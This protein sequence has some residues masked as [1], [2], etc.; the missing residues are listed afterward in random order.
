M[1]D[2]DGVYNVQ[3]DRVWTVVKL[4]RKAGETKMF[5]KTYGM[6]RCLFKRSYTI[7]YSRQRYDRYIKEVLPVVIKHGNNDDW[8]C[9][10]DNATPD[11]H[12]LTQEW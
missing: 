2:I 7:G 12:N 10:Q 5:S 8:T 3:N 9:Q 4:M 6:V 11:T 1:F